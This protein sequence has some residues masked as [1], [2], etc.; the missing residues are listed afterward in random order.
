[1]KFRQLNLVHFSIILCLSV[2]AYSTH[3]T[4]QEKDGLLKIYF[5]S[6]GQ[7]DSIFIEAP[8][9]NQVLIDGGPD[10][11]VLEK[12]GKVM[13]FYDRDID[14]VIASH[15]HSDHIMGLIDVLDRYNV[16]NIV[17]AKE[18]Y[19]SPQFWMWE[20]MIKKEGA[21]EIDAIANTVIDLGDGVVLKLLHPLQSVAGTQTKTPH[22]DVV[23]AMLEY[24]SFRVLLTGDME[25]K[26]E[27]K[28][29]SLGDDLKA[30]I[31]KVGH[32][33]SKT[34]SSEEFL[35]AVNPK[36]G[37]IE[38]GANNQY[39]LPAPEIL[40]RLDN[41]GIKYYRTDVDGDREVISDGES[42]QILGI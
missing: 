33:G 41:F 30:D 32:H 19:N 26:V 5:L 39:H 7:G 16:S 23:V 27:N 2:L 42:Y 25:A 29:I 1:M 21:R 17:E 6:V 24:G 22:D 11:K 40:Q 10:N 12:L 18:S 34:S 28:L 15:P 35:K 20:D 9:G 36:F 31:L 4:A 13:P 8:N 37:F 38:V 14:V 3:S